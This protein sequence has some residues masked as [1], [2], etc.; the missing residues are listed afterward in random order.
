MEGYVSGWVKA[1][2]VS[3]V[4]TLGR[5]FLGLKEEVEEEGDG[6][7]LQEHG[8]LFSLLYVFF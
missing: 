6:E 7:K 3:E 1:I 5:C 4:G 2:V 8:F